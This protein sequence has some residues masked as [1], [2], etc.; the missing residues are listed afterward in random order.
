MPKN[1]NIIRPR[2]KH[3]LERIELIDGLLQKY[4][5]I[6]TREDFLNRINRNLPHEQQITPSSLD[7]DLNYLRQLIRKDNV[8]LLFSR[9]TGYEYSELG[10]SYFKNSISDEDKKLLELAHNLFKIFSGTSLQQ[11][12][13]EIVKKVLSESLTADA[14][15]GLEES[16]FI[17]V[18]AGRSERGTLWIEVL[19]EAILKKET[20]EM[21]YKGFGKPLRKKIVSPYLLRNYR[22]R[23]YLVAYEHHCERK[24]KT[25]LFSVDRIQHLDVCGKKFY[26]DPNFS[27][28]DYFKYSIGIWQVHDKEPVLVRLEFTKFI[29]SVQ[30]NPIHPSQ[31]SMISEDGKRLTVEIEVYP[32]PELDMLIQGYGS[33]VKVLAPGELAN[34]IADKAKE[35]LSLYQQ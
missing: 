27:A 5:H 35:V 2:I 21:H 22:N 29:E 13:G 20:L 17:Q 31:K 32:S 23:W 18:E 11:K 14:A 4:K 34:R 8:K 25:N 15:Y 30:S 33:S 16:Y 28:A 7:K 6:Q 9:D 10:Y 24:E 26:T 3:S 19:L 12:F 1:K